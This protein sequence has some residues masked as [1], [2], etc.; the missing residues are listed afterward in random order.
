MAQLA[1]GKQTTGVVV[2]A[3][4]TDLTIWRNWGGRRVVVVDKPVSDC[5]LT[6]NVDGSEVG[7]EIQSL[8]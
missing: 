2:S 3:N 5:T 7:V 8:G 1:L 6:V 4:K